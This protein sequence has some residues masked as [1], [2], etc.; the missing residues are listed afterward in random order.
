MTKA[1]LFLKIL[2]R[3]K[4]SN[5][6]PIDPIGITTRTVTTNALQECGKLN[7]EV[8]VEVNFTKMPK[9]KSTYKITS[10]HYVVIPCLSKMPSD[11]T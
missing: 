6:T 5:M 9:S 2:H 1:L 3:I 11:L 10:F 7:L 4:V 8:F